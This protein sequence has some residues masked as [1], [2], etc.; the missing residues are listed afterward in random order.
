M[1]RIVQFG[2]LIGLMKVFVTVKRASSYHNATLCRK[3][4]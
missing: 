1:F 4:A 3:A 2:V